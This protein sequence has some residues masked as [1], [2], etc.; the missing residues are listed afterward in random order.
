MAPTPNSAL[1]AAHL[2]EDP[3]D[4][5]AL[6]PAARRAA[7]GGPGG[8]EATLDSGIAR[9]AYRTLR[10]A[11]TAGRSRRALHRTAPPAAGVRYSA[12]RG[13]RQR[14][15]GCVPQRGVRARMASGASVGHVG[16]RGCCPPHWVICWPTRCSM[17]ASGP[18]YPCVRRGA[19]KRCFSPVADNG[20]GCAPSAG[21]RG[22]GLGLEV[23]RRYARAYG[24][25]LLAGS[26]P[27]RGARVP[28]CL[29]LWPARR[30]PSVPDYMADRFVR[31]TCSLRLC[32]ICRCDRPPAGMLRPGAGGGLFLSARRTSCSAPS[33]SSC[34]SS[35]CS[36]CPSASASVRT[37]WPDRLSFS[38]SSHSTAAKPTL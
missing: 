10:A 22:L 1:L 23:A 29:P 4:L 17:A 8:G 20:P 28:L 15:G 6:L 21:D 25:R 32:A 7:A 37:P 33:A 19:G 26:A 5:L 14:R 38:P 27:E 18:Q 9:A 13:L 11:K 30:R 12:G 31:C 35:S 34:A 16:M 3:A 2:R 24:G 36:A